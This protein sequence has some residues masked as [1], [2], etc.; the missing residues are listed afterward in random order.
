MPT[1]EN[2]DI[3]RR[4]FEEVHNGRNLDLVDELVAVDEVHYDVGTTAMPGG[5]EI[6]KQAFAML[7][8]AFPDHHHSIEEMIAEGDKVVVRIT[9]SGTH[10]GE[11]MGIPPTGK[12]FSMTHTHTFRIADGKIIEHRVNRDDLGMMRQ[13]GV[14]LAP[15]PTETTFEEEQL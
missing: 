6:V 1:E 3:L 7:N 8:R 13:L 10:E 9:W 11:F 12:S 14:I 15:E 5:P 4:F 2:K